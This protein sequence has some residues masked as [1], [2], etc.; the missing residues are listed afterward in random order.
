MG[1]REVRSQDYFSPVDFVVG[2]TLLIY[3]RKFYVFDLDK[4]TKAYY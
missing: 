1:P 3:G 2:K 4:A